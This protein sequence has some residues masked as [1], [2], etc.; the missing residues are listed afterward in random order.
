MA[1]T[2][3]PSERAVC[4]A[5]FSQGKKVLRYE[6]DEGSLESKPRL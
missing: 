3:G 5:T 4:F 2:L 1:A 6:A